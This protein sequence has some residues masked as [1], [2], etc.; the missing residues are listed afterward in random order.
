MAEQIHGHAVLEMMLASGH[1]YTQ[2]SL[3]AAII[4]RFGPEARFYTCSAESL[5]ADQL[6]TFLHQRG[7]FQAVRKGF[8]TDRNAICHD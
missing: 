7:K 1:A 2:E 6:I 8:T 4:E 5:T 3:R